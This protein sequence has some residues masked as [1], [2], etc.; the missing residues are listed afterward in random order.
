MKLRQISYESPLTEAGLSKKEVREIS[1]QL[2]LQT[3]DKPSS[4]ALLHGFL[5]DNE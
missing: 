4:P 3:W 5:M 2:G 1:R